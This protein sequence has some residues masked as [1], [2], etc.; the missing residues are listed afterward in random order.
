MSRV[1]LN[2][3]I[4]AGLLAWGIPA[5]FAAGPAAL[6][7]TLA[8][9]TPV[10]L[11][12][13]R[14]GAALAPPA[15][16]SSLATGTILAS[17]AALYLLCDAIFGL[18]FWRANM[19]LF[20]TEATSRLVE[21]TVESM[22]RGGGVAYLLY[23][24]LFLLPFAL[25]DVARVLPGFIRYV[26]WTIAALF[27]FYEMGSGRAFLLLS[28]LCIILGQT[29]SW[30]RAGVAAALGAAAFG[31]ASAFRGDLAS[32]QNPMLQDLVSPF[33][34]LALLTHS[35]C[36]SAPW[37]S[38]IGEFLKKFVPAFL[39]PKTVFSF[40]AEMS[41]C[42]YPTDPNLT[43]GVSV[44]TWLGEIFYY[45]PSLVTALI[46]GLI[47]GALGRVVDRL[48]IK[49]GLQSARNMAGFLCFLL[50]RSRTQDLFSLLLA[51]LVFLV[52]FWPAL[53]TLARNLHRFLI[54]P[55]AA[56]AESEPGGDVAQ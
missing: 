28:V 38:F 17:F 32:A 39:F 41:M 20:G 22:G 13:L 34:N 4:V 2:D 45:R 31:V 52:I 51:Q 56:P 21:Q 26:L 55:H 8:A 27:I 46:A 36:G 16:R 37:Y 1:A 10:W 18:Q 44:F 11:L 40:N 48:L 25:I 9:V 54:A 6:L 15:Q 24:I 7:Y 50:P 35:S 47:L 49:N 33:V 19:F 42:I 53:S 30:R 29:W 14:N 12:R 43:N 3:F 23:S 5:A